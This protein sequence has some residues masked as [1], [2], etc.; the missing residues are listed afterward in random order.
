ML[1]IFAS[2][3]AESEAGLFHNPVVLILMVLVAIYIFFKFCSWAKNFQLSG[4]LKKWTFILTGIGVV[5]FNV[6]YNMGNSKIQSSGDW[7]GATIA[8]LASLAWVLVFAFVLMAE[9]KPE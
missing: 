1:A 2:A 6:L 9:T 4:S 8:L 5:F 7:G 3:A